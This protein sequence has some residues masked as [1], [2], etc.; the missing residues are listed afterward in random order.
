MPNSARRLRQELTMFIFG[1]IEAD[2]T[3]ILS[4]PLIQKAME[5]MPQAK[6]LADNVRRIMAQRIDR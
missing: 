3:Q 4:D 1:K 5:L 2:R 6:E